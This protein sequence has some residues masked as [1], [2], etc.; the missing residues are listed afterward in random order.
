MAIL[1][2]DMVSEDGQNSELISKFMAM[3]DIWYPNAVL[4]YL[5]FSSMSAS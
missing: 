3:D 5:E 4:I 2:H 1:S